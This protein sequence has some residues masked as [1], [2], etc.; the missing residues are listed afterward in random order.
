[1]AKKRQNLQ[2]AQ[3]LKNEV[4]NWVQTFNFLQLDVI[5]AVCQRDN[6]ELIEY[7][8]SNEPTWED[9]AEY[10]GE[11]VKKLKKEYN[12]LEDHYSY[13]RM[14]D[15]ARDRNYPMWNTLFEFK[16]STTPEIRNAAREAGIGII[17]GLADFNT[18]LFFSGCGY[19]FYGAH[20]IPLYLNLP[21][22]K[23]LLKK[24]KNLDYSMM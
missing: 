17:E 21:W 1:M 13:E 23:D 11:S 4:S 12:E 15:E 20:W 3:A 6:I 24:Y 7:I 10:T 5:E 14:Q 16:S 8:D 22:N 18:I 2:E 19:S 9:L